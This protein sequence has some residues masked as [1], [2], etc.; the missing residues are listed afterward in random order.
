[1]I[2]IENEDDSITYTFEK[3]DYEKYDIPIYDIDMNNISNQEKYSYLQSFMPRFMKAIESEEELQGF[4]IERDG[5][6]SIKIEFAPP[7]S[8]KINITKNND[9]CSL[10]TT[11]NP[12][13][14]MLAN[15]HKELLASK[16]LENKKLSTTSIT[17]TKDIILSFDKYRDVISFCESIK[18]IN[19]KNMKVVLFT[20]KETYYIGL[21]NLSEKDNNLLIDFLPINKTII[22]MK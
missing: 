11:N 6:L 14:D 4:Y 12:F 22:Q 15:R 10:N 19:I 1:M 16:I 18:S 5:L 3:E 9:N 7:D 17:K 21:E 20:C 13:M 2:I 8:L